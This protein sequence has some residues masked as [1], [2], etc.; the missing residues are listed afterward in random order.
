MAPREKIVHVFNMQLRR[1][2][3]AKIFQSWGT[4]DE[5][6]AKASWPERPEPK[7]PVELSK[8]FPSPP[9]VQNQSPLDGH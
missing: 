2:F 7:S 6:A 9:T 3:C 4:P 8:L 1:E 5:I